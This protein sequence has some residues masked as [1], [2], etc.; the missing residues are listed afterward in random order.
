MQRLITTA[1]VVTAVW[2]RCLQK[3][4]AQDD[5]N[6]RLVELTNRVTQLEARPQTTTIDHEKEQAGLVLFLFGAFCAL[7]A[8]NT[9]RNA[10]LW[11]FLGLLFNF[12]TVLFLLSK[13][14]EDR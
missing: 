11:F 3:A 4:S 13:N 6:R 7:W 10:W 5:M 9:N 14:S 8:Q 2:T 12:I 1:L